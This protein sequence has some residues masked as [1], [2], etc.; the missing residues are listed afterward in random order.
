MYLIT[1]QNYVWK[2][3]II[4]FTMRKTLCSESFE[5]FYYPMSFIP[6]KLAKIN[7]KNTV[8]EAQRAERDENYDNDRQQSRQPSI[9]Q[10]NK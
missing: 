5:L 8:I 9:N 7:K 1:V 6:N 10:S 2:P 3:N 4:L